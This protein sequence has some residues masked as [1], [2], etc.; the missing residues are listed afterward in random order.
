MTARGR[1]VARTL[2]SVL[3]AAFALVILPFE[4]FVI[5]FV[6][7]ALVASCA[8][9]MHWYEVSIAT[10]AER[11][12]LVFE[13]EGLRIDK[14]HLTEDYDSTLARLSEVLDEHALCPAPVDPVP[15][16]VQPL[17]LVAS[18]AVPKQRKGGK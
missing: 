14:R 3:F 1:T 10:E 12:H 17:H 8:V 16:I 7:I 6:V 9:A 15:L 11:I 5:G 4:L 13:V 18:G 2:T